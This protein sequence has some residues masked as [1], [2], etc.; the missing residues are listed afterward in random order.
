[1]KKK[2]I[3]KNSIQEKTN[4]GSAKNWNTLVRNT[5]N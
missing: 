5:A 3:D 4:I 2:K 1:M